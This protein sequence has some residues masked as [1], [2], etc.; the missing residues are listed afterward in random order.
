[1]SKRVVKT[2]DSAFKENAVKLALDGGTSISGVARDLGI[3]LST[4][5]GW[6]KKHG[7]TTRKTT[8]PVKS[9]EHTR[10][11]ELE[12]QNRRLVM[13]RDILKKAMAFFVELPK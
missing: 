4:L 5:H 6:V 12:K 13:E 1:M 11:A 10:I 9:D 2:F 3:G 7:Q 8:S